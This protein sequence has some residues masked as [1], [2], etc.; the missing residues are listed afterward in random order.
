MAFGGFPEERATAGMNYRFGDV[1]IDRGVFR[2]TRAGEFIRLE[3][4][5][6]ELLFFLAENPGRLVTKAE[7]QEAVW[8]GTFVTES[9]L[10][11]LVA[12]IR[13]GLGDDARE[14]R[15]IETVPTRGYRFIARLEPGN[16]GNGSRADG[17][18]PAVTPRRALGRRAALAGTALAALVLAGLGV[19]SWLARPRTVG[20]SPLAA[21]PRPIEKQVSTGAELNLS[22]RFSPEGGSIAYATLRKRS[23]EIVLRTLAPGAR[24]VAVTSDGMQNMQPAF[25]PDGRLIAYHSVGRGGIWLVPAL[26]GLPRR[27]TNFGS[28]PAWSPDGSRIAFQGQSWVAA[29]QTLWPASEG[30][31]IW[32]VPAAGGEPRQLTSIE[33]V[34]PGGQG[35]PAWSPDG[36]LVAFLSGTRVFTLRLED[37]TLRPTSGDLQVQ[38]IAWEKSGRS[39]VWTGSQSGN[40]CAWRVPVAPETGEPSGAPAILA[41]GGEAASAWS[42]PAPSPDGRSIAFVTYRTRYEILSQGV[43][44]DGRASGRPSPL[45]TTVAGR[46]VPLGFSP[47][48]R[49]FAFTTQRP[50]V[51]VSAWVADL[52][53]GD[54]RLVAEGQGM[55][56]ADAWF[57]DGRR[58]GYVAPSGHGRGF[59][60]V[61]VETGETREHR[62]L[63]APL[64]WSSRLSPDGKTLLFHGTLNGRLNV[65]RTDVAGGAERALTN[66]AEGIGWPVWS[67]DGRQ[68]AVEV[69]RGGDTRVGLLAASG[70]PVRDVVSTPGQNWPHSF[71]PDGRRIALAGQ[72]RGVWNVYWAPVA[73]GAEQPVTSYDSPAIY[74]RYPDWSP[75]GDRIAYEYAESASTVWVADLPSAER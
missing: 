27:L 26:G 61:D 36:K 35:S 72:R 12:Q 69:M 16:G 67:P 34:G 7:I 71:S 53:S 37:G 39:Q 24:E 64:W 11:R 14:A 10:T 49:R 63:D 1:E 20:A 59:W 9:A 47:D 28:N 19:R 44:P 33:K 43:T 52:A 30:S 51:G 55:Q 50:G 58:L 65:W 66:D 18:R 17:A 73:G 48:G 8:K 54:A 56:L 21:P 57:P 46:K 6:L 68:I 42:Q 15:Y 5:A 31:T 41:S 62:T 13:K 3:P 2:V 45:V 38:G 25:S 32:L 40:W 4:K 75:L 22:P 74:V 29:G 70:G 23:L 60:S